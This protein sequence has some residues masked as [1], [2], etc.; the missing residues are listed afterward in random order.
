MTWGSSLWPIAAFSTHMLWPFGWLIAGPCFTS[1]SPEVSTH[2]IACGTQSADSWEFPFAD[3]QARKGSGISI[4]HRTI[5]WECRV[6]GICLSSCE[7]GCLRYLG[8]PPNG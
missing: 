6:L 2:V 7:F 5:H 4:G 1:T 3:P 8:A